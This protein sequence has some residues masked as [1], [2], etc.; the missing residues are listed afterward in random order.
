VDLTPPRGTQDFLP[1]ASDRLLALYDAAHRAA[2]SFGYR[3]VETP[4]FESTDL[5]ARSSGQTSDV[6][7]K[8]MYMFEDRGGRSVT[9]RPEGTAPVVRAYLAKAHDLPTPFKGYYVET[10]FRYGR[11]QKG[12]LREFRT[13]GIEVL[14]AAEPQADVEVIDVGRLLLDVLRGGRSSLEGVELQLN[15]IGDETCRPA[16]RERL[17]GYLERNQDR[18]R[19]EH[20]DRFREN[21]LRVLDCKDDACREV[22]KDAPLIVDHLCEACAAHFAA[23]KEG[24]DEAGIGYTLT[25]TLVRGLDYYTRTAFEF[26]SPSLGPSQGTIIGG[27]RY[28]GLAEALGGPATPGVGFGSGIERLLLALGEGWD[29]RIATARGGRHPGLWFYVV[30]VGEGTASYARAVAR[31]LRGAYG[32]YSVDGPFAVRPLKAQLRMA[33]R[34]GAAYTVVVGEREREAGTLTLKRM[35][36]GTEVRDVT[37]QSALDWISADFERHRDDIAKGRGTEEDA[38]DT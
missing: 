38:G 30:A 14:G 4:T 33:D 25:P 37:P 16:Y 26:V 18:L 11:P 1:P 13:F 35:Q 10:L 29:P 24:L 5:F 8:E 19:D 32:A 20:R 31:G 17:I 2:T 28:D 36:D 12:R 22:S 15:S 9:L 6:V 3:Y 7:S 21:P 23:V 27:G 34:A